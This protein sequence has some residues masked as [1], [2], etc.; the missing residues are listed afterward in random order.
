MNGT[1]SEDDYFYFAVIGGDYDGYYFDTV[2]GGEDYGLDYYNFNYANYKMFTALRL[3]QILDVTFTKTL[4]EF[5]QVSKRSI[6][7]V[8]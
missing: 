3:V 2:E 8:C 6:R 1:E 5:V 4:A 7:T